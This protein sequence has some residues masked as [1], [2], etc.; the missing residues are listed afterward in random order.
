MQLPLL[1]LISPT[2]Y[3][4]LFT[5]TDPKSAKI[6]IKTSVLFALLETAHVKAL[7]KILVKLTPCIALKRNGHNFVTL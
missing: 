6:T 1:G 2:F 7:C 4:K 5:R 3:A